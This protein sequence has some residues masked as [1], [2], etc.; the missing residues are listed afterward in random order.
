[1]WFQPHSKTFWYYLYE[2]M[3]KADRARVSDGLGAIIFGHHDYIC[4]VNHWYTCV[5]EV[6]KGIFYFDDMKNR[7]IWLS[8]LGALLSCKSSTTLFSS[9]SVNGS[10]NVLRS[11]LGSCNLSQSVLMLVI[12]SFDNICEVLL[13]HLF[14]FLMFC[15]PSICFLK[16]LDVVLASPT[17]NLA[18]EEFRIC[19]PYLFPCKK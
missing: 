3:D 18:M 1:M 4:C 14:L 11:A 2:G 13:Y 15:C 16:V 8:S 10:S 5:L 12:W 9:H 17:I 6:V 19:I 7:H